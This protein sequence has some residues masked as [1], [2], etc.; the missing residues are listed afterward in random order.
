MDED[1]IKMSVL[2]SKTL[3]HLNLWTILNNNKKEI[4]DNFKDNPKCT[5]EN[6]IKKIKILQA[7]GQA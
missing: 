3:L 6:E 4:R 2:I 1:D 7:F 5:R